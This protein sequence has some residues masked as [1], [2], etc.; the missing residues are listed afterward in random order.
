[1]GGAQQWVAS[2]RELHNFR[3]DTVGV[4]PVAGKLWLR[5]GPELGKLRAQGPA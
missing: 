4:M 3:N 2:T 1:M 5:P